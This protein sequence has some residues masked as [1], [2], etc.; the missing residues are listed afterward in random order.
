MKIEY[1]TYESIKYWLQVNF[2]PVINNLSEQKEILNYISQKK[3]ILHLIS[4]KI[5]SQTYETP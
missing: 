4:N 5:A 3:V 1:Q 2:S